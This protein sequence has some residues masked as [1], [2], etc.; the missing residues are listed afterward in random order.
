MAANP[1][2][3]DVSQVTNEAEKDFAAVEFG[4]GAIWEFAQVE[5][6]QDNED[7]NIR[8]EGIDNMPREPDPIDIGVHVGLQKTEL[9]AM[10]ES[11]CCGCD[12]ATKGWTIMKNKRTDGVVAQTAGEE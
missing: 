8:D 2:P 7:E 11:A 4:G 9:S 1:Q 12:C 10:D 5:V 3:M 6:G